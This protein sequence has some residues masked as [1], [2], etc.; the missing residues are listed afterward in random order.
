MPTIT[1]KDIPPDIHEQLRQQAQANR[2][3]LSNEVIIRIERS[4]EAEDSFSS[5]VVNGLIDEALQSG[6]P[7][8]LT[9]AQMR[10]RMDRIKATN[11]RRLARQ[12]TGA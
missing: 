5:A 10:T 8:T 9:A 7:E 3:S 2:R 1:L 6:P 11:R 4:F 12:K